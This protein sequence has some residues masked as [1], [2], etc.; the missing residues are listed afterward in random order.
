MKNITYFLTVLLLLVLVSPSHAQLY[1]DGY[2]QGLFGGQLEKDNPTKSDQSVSE[3][4]LQVRMESIGDAG[5][6]F[7]RV[8]FVYD[9]LADETEQYDWEIREAYLKFRLGDKLDFKIGRQILTWGTGDLIFINDVFAKDYRSFFLGRDDQYLKAP[10]NALRMEYYNSIGAFSFV[11]SPTFESNRL[12]TGEKLSYYLPPMPDGLGGFTN[13]TIVGTEMG[14]NYYFNPD[15]PAKTFG[16][17]EF[18]A[19]FQRQ[20]GMYSLAFYFYK[21]FYKNPMGLNASTMMP[22]YPRLQLYGASLR[23]AK[24]GGIFWLEGGYYDSKDDPD[25]DNSFMPNSSLSGMIGFERQIATNLTVNLQ[26]QADKMIDYDLFEAQQNPSHH[27]RDEIKH[28]ITSRWTKMMVDETVMVSAFVFYSP[29][30]E[31][32]YFR[33][34]TE[35]K[36]SDEVTLTVGANVFDG[37]YVNTD[38]GQLSLN[39]N[40]YTKMTYNF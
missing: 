23:G 3:T 40:I 6:F 21:G 33:F 8:D 36:Y 4:R 9:G 15:E 34:S 17:S 39:D 2:V 11:F 35:Y 1:T 13:G 18:A 22:V 30:E 12:P 7:S 28:L 27:Y 10:Q 24:F 25:G 29:N 32:L 16:N 26:W 37:T 19:R 31:D 20:V 38:F 5:E 14:D